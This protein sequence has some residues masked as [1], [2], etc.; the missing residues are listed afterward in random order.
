MSAATTRKQY[1]CLLM[2]Q[3]KPSTDV[4]ATVAPKNHQDEHRASTVSEQWSKR[5]RPAVQYETAPHSPGELKRH[6]STSQRER[7]VCSRKMRTYAHSPPGGWQSDAVNANHFKPAK[8]RKPKYIARLSYVPASIPLCTAN[9]Y[10]RN[11]GDCEVPT[12]WHDASD[13]RKEANE[14]LSRNITLAST[15]PFSRLVLAGIDMEATI[16]ELLR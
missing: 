3:K 2:L 15:V 12:D 14:T 5:S 8:T 13:A 16:H 11:R 6:Q 4:S 10:G 1:S 7:L 9:H